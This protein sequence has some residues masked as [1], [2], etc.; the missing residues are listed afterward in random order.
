MLV[1]NI[2]DLEHVIDENS[3]SITITQR[4]GFLLMDYLKVF[5]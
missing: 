4:K 2:L 3:N 5:Q 1:Y